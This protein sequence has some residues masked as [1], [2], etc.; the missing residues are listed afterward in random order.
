M[1]ASHLKNF[2]EYGQILMKILL[3][4][5]EEIPFPGYFGYLMEKQGFPDE[6][7]HAYTYK[8]GSI[9]PYLGSSV[10]EKDED[11]KLGNPHSRFNQQKISFHCIIKFCAFKCYSIP[12]ESFHQYSTV[13]AKVI[14]FVRIAKTTLRNIFI[15]ISFINIIHTY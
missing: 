8:I 5:Y 7:D 15:N 1:L 3:L 2:E 10:L 9:Y 13:Y 6:F 14:L 11:Q 12:G 4:V